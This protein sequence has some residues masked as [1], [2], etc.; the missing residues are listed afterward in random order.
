MIIGL[1]IDIVEIARIEELLH[2]YENAFLKKVFTGA[3]IEECPGGT[4]TGLHY[5]GRWAAKEAFYKA[6][7]QSCQTHSY[8]TSVQFLGSGRKPQAHVCDP[9]L[10][11]AMDAA[12]ISA[13]HVSISHERS[14]CVAAVIL[15]NLP[16]DKKAH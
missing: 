7:P 9:K 12:G 3:E 13:M 1:G 15:E 10:K 6:L 4:K 14:M 2:K 8:F 11:E 5:A 16:V